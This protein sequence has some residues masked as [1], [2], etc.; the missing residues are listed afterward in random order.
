MIIGL[1]TGRG[2]SPEQSLPYKNT[3]PVLGRPAMLYPYLA[4]KKSKLIDDIYLSTD[5]E[6]LK[7]TARAEGIKIIDRPSQYAR[8]DSQHDECINHALDYLFELGI[9]VEIIVILMCNVAIQPEGSIDRCIQALLDDTSIDTAVTVREWGDHHPSR[10]KR[11]DEE[12]L[13]S[14]IV[15][16]GDERITTT[17]QLLGNC[18]YLD[19]QVWAFRVKGKHLPSD[20]QG[21]WYWMGHKIKGIANDD[22]VLDI[23]NIADVA[24]SEMWLRANGFRSVEE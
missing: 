7:E 15:T 4:A 10:A 1:L 2:G 13:L 14:P 17:R 8:A 6:D 23:H 19:H 22:L 11:M 20:G 24:Y 12:D 5:G 21:P 3:Y 9:D 18:Y 16:V